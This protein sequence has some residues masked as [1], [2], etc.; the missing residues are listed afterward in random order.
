MDSG[1]VWKTEWT[2]FIDELDV[3]VDKQSRIWYH[4]SLSWANGDAINKM[5]KAFMDALCSFI[6]SCL[7]IQITYICYLRIRMEPYQVFLPLCLLEDCIPSTDLSEYFLFILLTK[8]GEKVVLMVGQQAV[9]NLEV[10]VLFLSLPSWYVSKR[11]AEHLESLHFLQEINWL[12]YRCSH[13][14][15]MLRH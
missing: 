6:K 10:S 1:H 2:G 15:Q 9:S 13:S 12:V 11:N 8:L 5:K 4:Q 3:E 7:L 14:R